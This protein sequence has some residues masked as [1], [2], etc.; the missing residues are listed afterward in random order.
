M[1]N[2]FLY[3]LILILIA[4]I[5]AMKIFWPTPPNMNEYIKIGGTE[6]ILLSRKIDTIWLVKDSIIPVYTPVPGDVVHVPVPVD[7][8]TTAILKKYFAKNVYN[9][10]IVLDSV[11]YV[12]I[13]D[14]ISQNYIW[15]REVNYNYRIPTVYEMVIVEDKPRGQFYLGGGMNFD[16]TDFINGAYAGALFKTKTDKVFGLNIGATTTGENVKPYIGGSIYWK[17]KFGK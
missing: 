14:T 10:T 9:D 11:G 8:D 6:Y 16:K 13:R 15:S 2:K 5:L 12:N 4:I 17:I 7:V 1:K 3:I